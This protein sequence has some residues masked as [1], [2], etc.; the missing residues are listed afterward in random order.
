MVSGVQPWYVCCSSSLK[1]SY[2]QIIVSD[3]IIL[4][5]HIIHII[6]NIPSSS[7]IRLGLYVTLNWIIIL[8][9]QKQ[10]QGNLFM[11]HAIGFALTVKIRLIRATP[12]FQCFNL[13]GDGFRKEK[14]PNT[15]QIIVVLFKR[16]K[17][18]IVPP[19]P[20]ASSSS[21]SNFAWKK[22]W[23]WIR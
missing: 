14:Q 3:L 15:N 17:K 23:T 9:W 13:N 8:R 16:E 21:Y 10:G 22:N 4:C 6:H 19:P 1:S 7:S 20:F 18:K 12:V 11:L 2:H 5:H